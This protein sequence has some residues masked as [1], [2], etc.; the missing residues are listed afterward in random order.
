MTYE[1]GSKH[2][3][4]SLVI[5]N[6]NNVFHYYFYFELKTMQYSMQCN[7]F[8]LPNTGFVR[9][10]ISAVYDYNTKNLLIGTTGGEICVFSIDKHIFKSSFNA[11][12]N[13]TNN[14]IV[15]QDSS[16]IISGG[17]GKLKKLSLNENS[18]EFYTLKYEVDLKHNIS[19][20][21]ISADRSELICSTTVGEIY[22]VSTLNFQFAL[23]NENHFTPVNQCTF[24][25]ENDFFY[26]VD[27]LGSLI[28]WDL[29]DYTVINKIIG[30]GKDRAVSVCIGD[31][32][33][34]FVGFSNGQ[35]KCFDS[36]LTSMNW[37]IPAH[38]GR[39][40][41]IYVDGN[42][43]LTGGEDGVV[44]VWTRKT[45]ELVMNFHAHSKEV[46]SVFADK[47]SPNIIY[48][49]GEDKSMNCFDL[50]LQKRVIVHNMKNGFIFGM[51]QKKDGD[52]EIISVGFNCGFCV[53]DFYKIDPIMEMQIGNFFAIKISNSGRYFVLGSDSGEIWL[54][55]I[56]EYRMIGKASGHSQRIVSISWSPDDKQII[57]T[58]I[59]G[60]VAI[61][62][63]YID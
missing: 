59:D 17:D 35:L 38:R 29:N 61:W 34:V 57:S 22:R 36:K 10:F 13:G 8:S 51:D 58:S 6:V 62:N 33:T 23:H 2:A 48:S 47:N 9:T 26:S 63:F 15:L 14:I 54:F 39:I 52:R 5:S 1:E 20:L 37:E 43:I 40:N 42:Y 3:N 44:R 24:G 46:H 21:S 41:S 12:S 19:S 49:G 28:Q 53:W 7:K 16:L 56:L 11:I 30:N 18:K 27:D 25:K 4:Y 60:S 32:S 55:N 45:H 31:D 50:K